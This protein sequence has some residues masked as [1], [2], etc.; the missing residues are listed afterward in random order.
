[1]H[2]QTIKPND[3]QFA[4]KTNKKKKEARIRQGKLHCI[5]NDFIVINKSATKKGCL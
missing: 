3:A 4:V 1:M 2:I 5:C